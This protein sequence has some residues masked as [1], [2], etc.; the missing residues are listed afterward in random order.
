MQ[1]K[2]RLVKYKDTPE[3][4]LTLFFEDGA[5]TEVDLLIGA[6]GLR[7][8]SIPPFSFCNASAH[9]RFPSRPF[10]LRPSPPMSLLSPAKSVS[11]PSSPLRSSGTSFLTYLMPP[12]STTATSPPSSPLTSAT[13]VS[14]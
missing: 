3:G 1:L 11:A 6:D 2:K 9:P 14:S 4:A 12:S 5:T 13:I 7:S 8:V 10:A